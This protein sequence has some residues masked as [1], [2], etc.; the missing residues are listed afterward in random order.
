MQ[1]RS[2][3]CGPTPEIIERRESAVDKRSTRRCV[4]RGAI[5][6]NEHFCS[7]KM[8]VLCSHIRRASAFRNAVLIRSGTCNAKLFFCHPVFGYFNLYACL[9][10]L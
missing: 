3:D 5:L 4:S 6:M 10:A 7:A 1:G 2:R 9:L 8:S